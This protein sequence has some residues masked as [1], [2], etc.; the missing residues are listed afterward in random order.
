MTTR[1]QLKC[2]GEPALIRADGQAVKIK[3]RKHMALLVYLVL[4]NDRRHPREK[5]A[6]LLWPSLSDN[7]GRHSV[8]TAFTALRAAFGQEV[9]DTTPSGVRWSCPQLEVD[10]TR[11]VNGQI[12]GDDVIPPLDV[13]A[14]LDGFEVPDA[15]EFMFWRERQRAAWLP[16]IRDALVLLMD[17]CRRT[18][19]SQQLE[20]LADRMLAL[21]DLSEEAV[22]AKM[23]ARAFAGDRV[24]ALKIF[25]SWRERL[26]EELRAVPSERLEGLALRLRKRGWE[27]TAQSTVAS[28]RIDQWKDRPFIG[29]GREHRQLYEAWERMQ[30]GEPGHAHVLGESGIGKTTLVERLTTAAG[31]EGATS[32]RVQCYDMEREIPYAA[33]GGL[34]RSLLD[35]PGAN[36]A[37]PEALADLAQAVPEIRRRFPTIP[38]PADAVGETARLRIAEALHE[39]VTAVA[40]EHPLILVIDDHHLADDASLALLHHLLRR[41]QGQ[42]VMLVFIARASELGQSPHA[43]RLRDNLEQFGTVTLELAPMPVEDCDRLVSALCLIADT[44]PNAATRRALIRAARGYPMVLELLC[45][46]WQERGERSL[47]LSLDAMTTDPDTAVAPTETLGKLYDRIVQALDPGTR[48]VLNLAAILGHRVNDIS[49]YTVADL[50]LGQTMGGMSRLTALRVLRDGGD[51]LEFVNE[52]I[53]A[54]AYMSV[55]SAMRRILHA[56]IAGRL[57]QYEREGMEVL[58][59][60]IA[61]HCIRGG[62]VEEAV[63][64]LLR[65]ARQ[66]LQRGAPHE[67]ELA[68]RS[69]Y[70]L[71]KHDHDRAAA[72]LLLAESLSEQADWDTS[73]Q[74]LAELSIPLTDDQEA[75]RQA[76]KCI[77]DCNLWRYDEN[78]IHASL[79]DLADR[80][81]HISEPFS[82]AL[83]ARALSSLVLASRSVALAKRVQSF[84]LP[85]DANQVTGPARQEWLLASLRVR[86][87]LDDPQ[88]VINSLNLLS[89]EMRATK[90]KSSAA[91]DVAIGQGNLCCKMGKYEEAITHFDRSDTIAV[92]LGHQSMRASAAANKAFCYGTLGQYDKQVIFARLALSLER[93]YPNAYRRIFA[94]YNLARAHA[95]RGERV[96]ALMAIS[97][98]E[99]IQT[100]LAPSWVPQAK[101][102]FLADALWLAGKKRRALMYAKKGATGRFASPLSLD[103]AGHHSR[104]FIR[105]EASLEAATSG[106]KALAAKRT[107]L[108]VLD[109]LEVTAAYATLLSKANSRGATTTWAEARRLLGQLPPAVGP[110]LEQ[111]GLL[112]PAMPAVDNGNRGWRKRTRK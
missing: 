68:L 96:E 100:E 84:L 86:Y 4:E 95:M 79:E 3:V 39:L 98:M 53:R 77:A 18:G 32:A 45:Q 89:E 34:V 78:Q 38:R 76:L 106:L 47:A 37:S 31:L 61:W 25:E 17:R 102:L 74:I 1:F 72:R 11:L 13:G 40:D 111:F 101:Y 28:V 103:F 30:R 51:G 27:R 110:F 44:P 91:A 90:T 26:H 60:E 20:Q 5:L 6:E 9:L 62:R 94:R 107:S 92:E 73:L 57:I 88:A 97:E 83:V 80:F 43:I 2:L 24:N 42:K 33:I 49:M 109:Q 8:N 64:Y 82:I 87:L 66:A 16:K 55:P 81:S 35:R 52:L 108:D 29:R 58:G 19:D 54:H 70:S 85:L 75:A 14:F 67:V 21:D 41:V 71:L 112:P 99:E 59:L 105:V 22:R 7:E 36:G 50:S 65:G 23:E 15:S 63:P 56:N 93:E 46:D 10:L 12:L 48:N 104:W 69:G